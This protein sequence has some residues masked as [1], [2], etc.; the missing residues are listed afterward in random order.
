TLEK[1]DGVEILAAAVNVRNPLPRLPRIIEIKHRSHG[2]HAQTVDVIFVEPEKP[3]ADEKIAHLVAAVI[4]NERA[5]ILMLALTGV[6]VL[7]EVGAVELGQ[8]VCVL[9]KM[10][11]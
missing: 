1:I 9:R 8:R 6:L 11:R 2:I 7:V 5:P 4:E 3:V 10:R